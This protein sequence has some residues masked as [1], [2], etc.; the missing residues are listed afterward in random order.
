MFK[1]QLVHFYYLWKKSIEGTRSIPKKLLKF[2]LSQS[3]LTNPN[4]GYIG[5]NE[6]IPT[7]S[8]KI[9]SKFLKQKILRLKKQPLKKTRK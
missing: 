5:I 1:E 7:P 8:E 2:N 3:K 9:S 4:E 6:N